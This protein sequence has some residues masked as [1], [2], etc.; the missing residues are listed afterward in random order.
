MCLNPDINFTGVLQL[1]LKTS[2]I[3]LLENSLA[4]WSTF[5]KLGVSTTSPHSTSI[6][7]LPISFGSHLR[8]FPDTMLINVCC[9]YCSSNSWKYTK[10]I[11]DTIWWE[12]LVME[13]H[14]YNCS[15]THYLA[16]LS[17]LVQPKTSIFLHAVSFECTE[18]LCI[19]F[20]NQFQYIFTFK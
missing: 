5:S 4:T 14:L 12:V 8:F 1:A 15:E 3:H 19:S 18:K 9:V 17:D 20:I 16:F 13:P 7:P 10:L 11:Y 6:I 2:V